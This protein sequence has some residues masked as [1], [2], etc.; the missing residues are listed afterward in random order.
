MIKATDEERARDHAELAEEAARAADDQET[1][2]QSDQWAHRAQAH[3]LIS[4]AY[5]LIGTG[6]EELSPDQP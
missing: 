5:T 6:T 4:I 2:A 3:A 1:P